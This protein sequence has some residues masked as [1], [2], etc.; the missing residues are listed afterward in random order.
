VY[1]AGKR[2]DTAGLGDG[3]R[4]RVLADAGSDLARCLGGREVS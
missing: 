3:H 2:V 1:G 4:Q